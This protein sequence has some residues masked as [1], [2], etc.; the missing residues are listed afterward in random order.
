MEQNELQ[1]KLKEAVKKTDL[2][3]KVF[4]HDPNISDEEYAKQVLEKLKQ[5]K[6]LKEKK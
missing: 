5:Q 3:K 4:K 1:N 6:E 2:F